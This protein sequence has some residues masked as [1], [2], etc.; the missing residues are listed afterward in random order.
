MFAQADEFEVTET[1]KAVLAAADT[2]VK[3]LEAAN[4]H[5]VSPTTATKEALPAHS[6]V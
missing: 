1:N 2:S 6:L 4:K 5:L 3:L